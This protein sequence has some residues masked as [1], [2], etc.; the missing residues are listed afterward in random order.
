MTTLELNTDRLLS[1]CERL[2]E[3]LEASRERIRNLGSEIIRLQPRAKAWGKLIDW[4]D[5]DLAEW[6]DDQCDENTLQVDAGVCGEDFIPGS[7][8]KNGRRFK[9]VSTVYEVEEFA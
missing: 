7:L 5:G 9:L 8:V 3:A 1:E 4:R 2:K 6:L